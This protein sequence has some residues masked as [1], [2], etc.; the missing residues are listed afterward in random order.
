MLEWE[1][2]QIPET[3]PEIV[4]PAHTV[5]IMHS[6][7]KDNTGSN[8]VFA[9]DSRFMLPFGARQQLPANSRRWALCHLRSSIPH[10]AARRA[11]AEG[12]G[13]PTEPPGPR[14][15]QSNVCI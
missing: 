7:Q 12:Q 4:D 5:V 1:S 11:G 9:R 8:G 10:V 3:L 2:R 13:D 15:L 6:A 14:V